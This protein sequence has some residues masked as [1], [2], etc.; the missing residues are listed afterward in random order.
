MKSYFIKNNLHY[1]ICNCFHEDCH[2]HTVEVGGYT[3]KKQ[4]HLPIQ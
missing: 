2:N 3:T 4:K 1:A